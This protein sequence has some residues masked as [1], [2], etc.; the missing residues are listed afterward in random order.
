LAFPLTSF[1]SCGF[2]Q[3]FLEPGILFIPPK[4]EPTLSIATSTVF[5]VSFVTVTPVQIL[6]SC[7]KTSC[8]GYA[9]HAALQSPVYRTVPQGLLPI[10]RYHCIWKSRYGQQSNDVHIQRLNTFTANS[11][12]L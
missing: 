6:D 10:R 1:R 11:E 4:Y 12:T 8:F 5:F 9:S 7:M 3:L 2:L